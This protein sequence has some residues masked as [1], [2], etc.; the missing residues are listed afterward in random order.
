[1]YLCVKLDQ[2]E[3]ILRHLLPLV[4][5]LSVVVNHEIEQPPNQP[6]PIVT[7]PLPI[8][9]GEGS[10]RYTFL[11]YQPQRDSSSQNPQS[12]MVSPAQAPVQMSQLVRP[13]V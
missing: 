9:N 5:D 13:P 11:N 8:A 3:P 7:K 12:N 4:Q 2:M 6:G 10:Y 1:M